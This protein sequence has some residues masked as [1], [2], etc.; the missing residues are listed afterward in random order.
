M[1]SET[2]VVNVRYSACD[3]RIDRSGPYG[4]RYILGRD[5]N[6]ATVIEKHERDWRAMLADLTTRDQAITCLRYMKGKRLGCHCKPL[7]CHSDTYVRLI[8]EFCV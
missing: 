1:P 6:R 8:A 5:G 7:A 4:N 2:T 3:L